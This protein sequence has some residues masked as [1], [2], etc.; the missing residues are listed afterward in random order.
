MRSTK[1]P[2][3]TFIATVQ[4]GR[5][6]SAWPESRLT[7]YELKW[8]ERAEYIKDP[9]QFRGFFAGEGNRTYIP[10]QFFDV[11]MPSEALA[12]V[13]VVGSVIRFSIG[14]QTRWGHRRQLVSL[15]YKDIR[16]YTRHAQTAA[17]FASAIRK[18]DGN[19]TTCSGL[20]KGVFDPNAGRLSRPATYALK[21][22]NP[23]TVDRVERSEKRT[24][25]EERTVRKSRPG[26]VRKPD[27][28]NGQKT[29][30]IYK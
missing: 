9:K 3:G 5:P 27:R 11:V 23:A 24:G 26:T 29:R 12:V 22:L 17:H 1:R 2:E 4:L 18:C 14:F 20:R 21:W 28:A 19:R 6:N 16:N 13:K 25:P 30:P 8:D 15:S 7:V 10:N